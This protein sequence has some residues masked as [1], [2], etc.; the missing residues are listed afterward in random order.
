MRLRRQVTTRKSSSRVQPELKYEVITS[1]DRLGELAR[2]IERLPYYGLDI[3]T[4]SND[5]QRD[6][7]G[8]FSPRRGKIR[9]IQLNLDGKVSVVDLFQ[10]G[11]P[12]PLCEAMARTNA[13]CI[14]QN[15]KFESNWFWH[16]YGVEFKRLF[17]TWL[18]SE[19]IACGKSELKHNLYD[20]WERWLGYKPQAKD[21]GGTDWGV[22]NLSKDQ[23]DYAAEDV[24]YLPELR[25]VLK[26]RLVEDGLVHTAKLEFDAVLP[27]ADCEYNGFPIDQEMWRVL[28][29]DNE[30]QANILQD[31]LVR[32]LPSP[33][34]QIGLFGFDPKFN[35]DSTDQLLTSLRKLGLMQTVR[36]PETKKVSRVLLEATN[37]MVLSEFAGSVPEIDKLLKYKEYRECVKKY[38]L[39]FLRHVDQQTGRLHTS[40]YPVLDTGRYSSKP[41]MQNIPRD[42]RFRACFRPRPGKAFVLS[43]WSGAQMRIVAEISRDPEL[44]KVFQS[45]D[46]L[47]GDP[48]YVTAS[49]L[50]NKPLHELTKQH[51]QSAK[52]VNFG[53]CFGLGYFKFIS[54]ARKQ[55]G[56]IV[57]ERES[58]LFRD[59]YF[60]KYAGI[61]AWHK[62]A[63]REGERCGFTRTIGGRIRYLKPDAHNEILNTP[64]QGTEADA[65]KRALRLIF[66]RLKPLGEQAKLVNHIHDEVIAEIDDTPE[67]AATVGEILQTS[68]NEAMNAYMKLVP[69]KA[70]PSGAMK[71]W[72][73]K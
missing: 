55:Y 67:M 32:E 21:L 52:A 11:G 4:A 43:D 35:I 39:P 64:V 6:P 31:Q 57:T 50:L 15:L 51:K 49:A 1:Q 37:E 71:S 26:A 63:I 3:E 28:A 33:T 46:K 38:G 13:I 72:A 34:G 66:D 18:S 19:V 23:L 59:K 30:R 29:A 42:K 47:A 44:I 7:D 27:V 60:E 36:D 56:V 12:G 70:D 10:T 16:L 53:Y 20:V 2:L 65:L 24:L 8:A 48:H 25:D 40:F 9:L 62:R 58:K 14:G 61:A 73:E 5:R 17:D 22:P 41:N 45:T 68:M 54:Y 69:S